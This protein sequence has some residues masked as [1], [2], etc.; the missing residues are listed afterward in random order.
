MNL[1]VELF[2]KGLDTMLSREYNGVDLSLGTWQRIA[3]ARAIYKDCFFIVLDEPTS[4]IDPLEE[5]NLYNV[6]KEIAKGKTEIIITHRLGAA[7][8][9][10]RIIVMS[11]GRIIEEGTHEELIALGGEYKQNW[12]M[13]TEWYR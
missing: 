4:A 5:S 8:L 1:N 9:A 3:I 7:R 2:P 12:D 10:D 11:K 6:F 13:Q